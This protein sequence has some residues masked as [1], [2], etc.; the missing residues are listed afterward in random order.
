MELKSILHSTLSMA[1][2]SAKDY[3]SLYMH[4][5]LNVHAG[6][7]HGFDRLQQLINLLTKIPF[8]AVS[9]IKYTRYIL[10]NAIII[11]LENRP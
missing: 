10:K 6:D 11:Y 9:N 3:A 7:P 4:R 5:D 1:L 8:R 2:N